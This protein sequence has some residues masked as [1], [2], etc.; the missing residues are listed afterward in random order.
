WLGLRTHVAQ[1]LTRRLSLRVGEPLSAPG[2]VAGFR[3]ELA[4][5]AL[6]ERSGVRR[7]MQ[8]ATLVRALDA[9]RVQIE[10]EADALEA[11][12]VVLAMGGL[13]SGGIVWAPSR[14]GHGF[15][16]SLECPASFAMAGHPLLPGGSP[17]GPLFEPF[18]WSGR[19]SAPGFERVGVWTDA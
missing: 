15:E 9:T 5:D 19:A 1:E 6:L 12:V 3:F 8:K 4:R 13:A 7:V 2:G 16:L 14:G 10:L 18:A 11:D 17:R